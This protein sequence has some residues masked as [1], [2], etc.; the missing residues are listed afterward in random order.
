MASHFL[1]LRLMRISN[2][3]SGVHLSHTH[4]HMLTDARARALNTHT[5]TL[6]VPFIHTYTH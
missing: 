2:L 6:S 3:T 4:T 1:L 5:H